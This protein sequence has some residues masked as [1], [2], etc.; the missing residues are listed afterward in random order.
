MIHVHTDDPAQQNAAKALEHAMNRWADDWI[1]RRQ[2][3]ALK[4]YDWL[5]PLSCLAGVLEEP[6]DPRHRP[7]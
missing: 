1:D 6:N 4:G 3:S 7:A 2:F 5:M